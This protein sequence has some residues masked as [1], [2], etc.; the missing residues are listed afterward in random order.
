M[1][2]C[3]TRRIRPDLGL[4]GDREHASQYTGALVDA[5]CA[6]IAGATSPPQ[7]PHSMMPMLPETKMSAD[8]VLEQFQGSPKA[9][10]RST[11]VAPGQS[12]GSLSMP[13]VSCHDTPCDDA[14]AASGQRSA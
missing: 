13:I 7:R 12:Q 3:P 4:Q 2:T 1:L 6:E 8:G 9:A 5:V 10:L 14:A 11:L